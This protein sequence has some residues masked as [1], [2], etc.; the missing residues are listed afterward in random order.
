MLPELD[1]RPVVVVVD[2]LGDRLLLLLL[3][4]WR[5]KKEKGR[6]ASK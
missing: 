1:D 5:E 3:F 4:L 6:L 2:V